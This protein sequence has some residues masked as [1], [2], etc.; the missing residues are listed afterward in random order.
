MVLYFNHSYPPDRGYAYVGASRV[1]Y[2]KDLY[3]FGLLRQSDWLPVG[4]QPHEEHLTRSVDS[5]SDSDD[6]FS[7][8]SEETDD[9]AESILSNLGDDH[10]TDDE[11][12]QDLLASLDTSNPG[13]SD[14]THLFSES[15][16]TRQSIE[17]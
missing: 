8:D 16:D 13:D 10:N 12:F 4:G 7:D 17:A 1:R 3:L 5:M 2:A 9:D 6:M 15:P 11:A 14:W